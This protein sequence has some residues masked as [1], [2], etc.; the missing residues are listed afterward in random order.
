MFIKFLTVIIKNLYNDH[1]FKFFSFQKSRK[2]VGIV[3]FLPIKIPIDFNILNI[4][5]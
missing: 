1:L 3:S 2:N 5:Y 4:F